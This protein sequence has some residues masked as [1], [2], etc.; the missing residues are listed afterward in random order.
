MPMVPSR[1]SINLFSY[2]NAYNG[3]YLGVSNVAVNTTAVSVRSVASKS[4]PFRKCSGDM[5]EASKCWTHPLHQRAQG[6]P[7][8]WAWTDT[9]DVI[10]YQL[11]ERTIFT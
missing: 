5:L 11:N 9:C 4:L 10:H 3:T 1:C 6:P 8:P 7:Q 2:V